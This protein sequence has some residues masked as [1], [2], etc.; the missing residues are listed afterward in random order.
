MSD[1][2]VLILTHELLMIFSV[3]CVFEEGSDRVALLGTWCPVRVS[4]SQDLGHQ[5][6]IGKVNLCFM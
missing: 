6:L 5:I 3:P 4:P 1:L 2:P